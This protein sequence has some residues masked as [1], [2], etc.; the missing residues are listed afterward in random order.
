MS[1]SDLPSETPAVD[2]EGTR[3]MRTLK[4]LA[5]VVLVVGLF[6][7]LGTKAYYA[8]LLKMDPGGKPP[9]GRIEVVEGFF[10]LEG[11]YNPGVTFGLATGQTGYILVFTILATL[12]L[13]VWLM[14]TR[15]NSIVLHVALGMV[16]AGALGNLWDRMHWH[17][18]RDFFLIY[19]GD[20]A[21]PSFEWPNFNV[22]DS[23]IVSGVILILLLE[24]FGAKRS[25]ESASA[26]TTDAS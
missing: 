13:F 11:T 5:L 7:D 17:K 21:N 26:G 4:I 19:T 6:L 25:P 24:L 18:V 9:F 20:P 16:L 3:S 14:A 12:A 1:A 15:R 10:A 2:G 8:D 23:M 22:A